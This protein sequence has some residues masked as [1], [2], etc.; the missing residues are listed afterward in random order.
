MKH[1][2]PVELERAAVFAAAGELTAKLAEA[3]RPLLRPKSCR[4]FVIRPAF[5]DVDFELSRRIG[6]VKGR[7]RKNRS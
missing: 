1:H 2:A 5:P 4:L 3:A 7:Y 6:S